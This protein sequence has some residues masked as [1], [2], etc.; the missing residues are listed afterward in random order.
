[1]PDLFLEEVKVLRSRRY[2]TDDIVEAVERGSRKRL[3][4]RAGI[5]STIRD[6]IPGIR[7]NRLDAKEHAQGT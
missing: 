5:D 2:V 1:M 7:R 4:R 6:P 3:N